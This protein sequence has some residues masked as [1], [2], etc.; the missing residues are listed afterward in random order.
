MAPPKRY[1]DKS[2]SPDKKNFKER[3]DR[4]PKEKFKPK[5]GFIAAGLKQ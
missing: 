5:T 2:S 4:E 1:F 3:D